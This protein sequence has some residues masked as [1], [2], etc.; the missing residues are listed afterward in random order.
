MTRKSQC[1]F[2]L[3]ELLVSIS[4]LV[5]LVLLVSRIFNS[6]TAVTTLRQKRMDAE[7]QIRPLFGRMAVDFAQMVKRPY[8]DY[9]FKATYNKKSSKEN[10]SFFFVVNVNYHFAATVHGLS[11]I[12]KLHPSV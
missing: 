6:V 2:T 7:S 5:G 1:A 11:L 8:V 9:L 4:V 10:I 12:T 3:S